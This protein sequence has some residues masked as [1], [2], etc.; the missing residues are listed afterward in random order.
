MNRSEGA[1][2][3]RWRRAER[4]NETFAQ[5]KDDLPAMDVG[6]D[7]VSAAIGLRATPSDFPT[8]AGSTQQRCPKSQ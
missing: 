6:I 4:G 2:E 5:A 3:H 1:T 7:I 8:E